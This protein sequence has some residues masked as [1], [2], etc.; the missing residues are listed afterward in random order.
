MAFKSKRKETPAG[1][2][3][4]HRL[5]P[6]RPPQA[7]HTFPNSSGTAKAAWCRSMNRGQTTQA[8]THTCTHMHRHTHVQGHAG[9]SEKAPA[10]HWAEARENPDLTTPSFAPQVPELTGATSCFRAG[11]LCH[12]QQTRAT[13][14]KPT[15]WSPGSTRVHPVRTSR[16]G[17]ED[18]DLP[19]FSC[20]FCTSISQASEDQKTWM[21]ECPSGIITPA[22]AM[23]Q[24]S[25]SAGPSPV[26]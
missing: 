17:A 23:A 22:P 20:C 4:R 2:F 26:S 25:G 15:A 9:H 8:C 11:V 21:S 3:L 19:A 14:T 18:L 1:S 12:G 10:A 13:P 5:L 6:S 24:D 7:R 16:P